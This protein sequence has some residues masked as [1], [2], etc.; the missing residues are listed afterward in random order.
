[1]ESQKEK[2][3]RRAIF[4]G[5]M[6]DNFPKLMKDM[7]PQ[8][9]RKVLVKAGRWLRTLLLLLPKRRQEMKQLCP[10]DGVQVGDT[11]SFGTCSRQR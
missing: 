5:I 4:E 7:N 10:G 2:H 1:M 9:D 8:I 3:G 11:A 6:A